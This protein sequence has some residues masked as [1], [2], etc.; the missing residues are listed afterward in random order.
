[1]PACLPAFLPA[2]AQTHLP[3][4]HART[5]KA[6][7]QTLCHSSFLCGSTRASSG[8]RLLARSGTLQVCLAG[9]NQRFRP[10]RHT[11]WRTKI[12]KQQA[13]TRPNKE[14][15][16]RRFCA[17]RLQCVSL[18]VSLA[19]PGNHTANQSMQSPSRAVHEVHWVLWCAPRDLC[20]AKVEARV[21]LLEALQ[22][23]LLPRLLY[24]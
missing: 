12:Q 15:H 18:R 19:E 9:T 2:S 7:A 23:H 10:R 13:N 16:S 8:R 6:A 3:D 5:H 14:V 17:L 22:Q 1:M 20:A 24:C 4:S 11:R 21:L